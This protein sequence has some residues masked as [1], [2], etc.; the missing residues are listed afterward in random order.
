MKDFSCIYNDY[1]SFKSFLVS[2]NI[3]PRLYYLII[4]N[5][6]LNEAEKAVA[7]AKELRSIFPN[8]AVIGYSTCK[9]AIHGEVRSNGTVVRILGFENSRFDVSLTCLEKDTSPANVAL[10][11]VGNLCNSQTK[12]V[13]MFSSC[14]EFS[15]NELVAEFNKLSPEIYLVGGHVSVTLNN[16]SVVCGYLFDEHGVYRN[17]I[18]SIALAGKDLIIYQDVVS[19]D[20]PMGDV[21][22]LTKV[23]GS[24][25]LEISGMPAVDFFNDLFAVDFRK[26]DDC[27]TILQKFSLD[28]VDYDNASRNIAYDLQRKMIYTTVPNCVRTGDK[29]RLSYHSCKAAMKNYAN[30]IDELNLSPV[31]SMFVFCCFTRMTH[32]KKFHSQIISLFE[33][34]NAIFS[35]MVGELGYVGNCSKFLNNVAVYFGLTESPDTRL[36]VLDKSLLKQV[37]QDEDDTADVYRNVLQRQSEEIFVAKEELLKKIMEHEHKANQS[38][39]VEKNTGLFNV[40]KFIYDST[41]MHYNKI[42][43]VV[44]EKSV[45][46]ANYIGH[47]SYI[48]YFM[49]NLK[50][51]T[52]YLREGGYLT[53]ENDT[54]HVHIYINDLSSF[55]IAGNDIFAT[56]EFM[57]LA[58]RLFINFNKHYTYKNMICL[59]NFF[60]VVDQD[61]ELLEKVKL[62]MTD[63][64]NEL[65]RFVVYEDSNVSTENF[66]ESLQA[67]AAINYAIEN[68][69][70]EPYFQPIYDNSRRYTHKFESLMRIRDAN[71]KI[72]YPNQFLPV[73]KEFRLYLQLSCAMINKV[74]DLF[75][76]REE[77]VSINL[78]AIDINSELVTDMI[79]TRLKMVKHPERFIFEIL[80]SDAFEDLD[81]LS[82]FIS[83][84]RNYHVL[85][86]IDDFGAGYSNLLEIVKLRPDIIKIDGEIVKH[87]LNDEVNRNIIDV[88]IYLAKK[89]NVD[90]V[91]EYAES[92]EL[93]EFLQEKGIRYSQGYYFSK[94]LPYSQIDS[95]L[96]SEHCNV[97]SDQPTENKKS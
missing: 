38:L 3:N 4:I 14:F 91:A 18:I 51:F 21:Y 86:A 66:E 97:E 96:K 69:G 46:L 88:I 54:S 72:W 64:A 1:S 68:D 39:F 55:I 41:R 71:N 73:A 6:T 13:M 19:S 11:V 60:V 33:P 87:L 63:S 94:P 90:L 62:M 15:L 75:S 92:R 47:D 5:T 85:I 78:S 2:S 17:H 44:I 27:N 53:D 56:D 82:D 80:E 35:Y 79:Y 7:I 81:V 58:R 31:M 24:D 59:N 25:I 16:R 9:I 76:D 10:D 29:V 22:E 50:L 48:A 67:L 70:I 8:S 89:F 32:F 30:I 95:Y 40:E 57:E 42:V 65:K 93:Q 28:L 45:Q 37:I 43:M 52:D 77:S 20:K 49:A 84:L 36:P 26:D 34:K 74:F 61:T 83:K 23:D 12:A